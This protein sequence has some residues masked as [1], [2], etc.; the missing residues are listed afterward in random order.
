M[1]PAPA[2]PLLVGEGDGGGG[3]GDGGG[4][5][6]G[7]SEGGGGGEATGRGGGEDGGESSERGGARVMFVMFVMFQFEGGI[8]GGLM[9]P[10]G[11][12]GPEGI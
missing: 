4:G 8:G 11:R 6:G 9:R 7:G 1:R 3:E 10:R 5:D 12:G 2:V